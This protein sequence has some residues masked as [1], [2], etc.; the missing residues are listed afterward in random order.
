MPTKLLPRVLWRV[1][2]CTIVALLGIWIYASYIVADTVSAELERALGREATKAA[3][4]TSSKLTS[5][6]DAMISLT[7]NDLIVNGLIDMEDRANY[8]PTFFQS[9]QLPGTSGGRVTLADYRGRTI[10]TNDK[11]M[12]YENAPWLDRALA[13]EHISEFGSFGMV[14]VIPVIWQGGAEGLIVMEQDPA[15]LDSMLKIIS[16]S[17]AVEVWAESSS[18]HYLSGNGAEADV[19]GADHYEQDEWVTAEAKV[20]GFPNLKV[21]VKQR[22]EL[23][24]ASAKRLDRLML[25]AIV[26]SILAITGGIIATAYFTTEPLNRFVGTIEKIGRVENLGNRIEPFGSAEFHA[27]SGSL[28][29][30]LENLEK[31]TTSRDYFNTVLNSLSE[32]L[33]LTDLSGRVHMA[34]RAAS[35]ITG[36]SVEE[37]KGQEI[38][39]ILRVNTSAHQVSKS[40]ANEE[41]D[42]PPMFEGLLIVKHD[43]EIPVQVSVAR[44]AARGE[45]PARKVYVLSDITERKQS[46]RK[47]ADLARL[48]TLT[49]LANRSLFQRRLQDALAQA[50]RTDRLVGLLLLD[51]DRFKEINDTLGHPAGDALLREVGKRLCH[52]MRETDT[53]ARLGGDEFAIIATNLESLD[54]I[55]SIATKLMDALAPP[56]YLDGQEV[57]TSTSIGV[58]VCPPE[59]A[60]P[61]I[62]FTHADF[63]LYRAK[64]EGR[65]NWEFFDEKMNAQRNARKELEADLERAMADDQFTLFYQPKVHA[66]TG[67]LTG[68]EALIRWHHPEKGLIPPVDFIPIAESVGKIVELGEW[69]MQTACAQHVAWCK[70]G[71]APIPVSVNLSAVQFKNGGLADT[72]QK[73]TSEHGVDPKYLELEITESTIIHNLDDVVRQLE[74]L[75]ALGYRISIDD[76]GTGYSS[77]AYLRRFP[78]DALKIDRSFVSNMTDNPDDASITAAIVSLASN[79][80]IDVVAEGVETHDQLALLR[81]QGC[82]EVQGY[83]FKPPVPADEFVEWLQSRGRPKVDLDAMQADVAIR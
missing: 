59:K 49:G 38:G 57:R 75:H 18:P 3:E 27:L 4:V 50:K 36:W 21:V 28:N 80:G 24:F 54:G 43:S 15:Q 71:L 79:L 76:F 9:F 2:P 78:I 23:A 31:T 52:T 32:L 25:I 13:G 11:G 29:H 7:R 73:V 53:V 26:M 45:I 5:A 55:G 46:E 42:G 33:L 51:L 83:L 20:P 19:R 62:M 68:V 1:L 56:F 81:R 61:D 17:H 77:L 70:A 12:G 48:D 35:E 10:A 8:L 60:D 47:L 22:T 16:A 41:T 65:G 64:A 66:V 63:A 72:V 30:M 37:L 6:M 44:M 34:N 58:S 69:V 74:E 67:D 40:D 39:A 14:A 82:A